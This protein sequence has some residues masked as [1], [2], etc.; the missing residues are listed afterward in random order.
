[1][2][3]HI[4]D[5]FVLLLYF[6]GMT[7][8]GVWAARKI[9]GSDDFFMPRRFGKVM[10]IMFSFGAGKATQTAFPVS[11]IN[12]CGCSRRPFIGSSLRF[13]DVSGL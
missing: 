10:M 3:L 4:A 5:I 8:I 7:A 2:G 6:A 12:G 9:K 13:S 11:G 1:M